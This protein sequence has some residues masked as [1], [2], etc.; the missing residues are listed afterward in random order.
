MARSLTSAWNE[1]DVARYKAE[2]YRMWHVGYHA[3]LPHQKVLVA[4]P[5]E[6]A[7]APVV[8]AAC[9][10][11]SCGSLFRAAVAAGATFYLTGE[12]RHHDALAAA[13]AGM[14]CLCVGHSHSERITLGRVA[15]RLGEMLPKLSVVTAASDR[16]PFEIV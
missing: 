8:T 14:T 16:D 1:L 4:A 11:G 9:G 10:A 2:F 5:P 6:G 15:R 7:C 13:A 3:G 12:M